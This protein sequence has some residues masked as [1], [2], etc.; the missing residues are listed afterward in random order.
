MLTVK[1]KPVR[2]I[3]FPPLKPLRPPANVGEVVTGVYFRQQ[4]ERMYTLPEDVEFKGLL[5]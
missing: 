2:V 3:N 1:F 5:A 4:L